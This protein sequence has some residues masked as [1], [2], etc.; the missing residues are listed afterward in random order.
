MCSNIIAKFVSG[1]RIELENLYE[2]WKIYEL[3]SKT[4]ENVLVG[5]I[6]A[7]FYHTTLKKKFN[8]QNK[9]P[10]L[11]G[12]KKRLSPVYPASCHC[13]GGQIRTRLKIGQHNTQ[14]DGPSP[15]LVIPND[16]CPGSLVLHTNDALS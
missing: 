11:I 3:L 12:N 7:S 10:R 13:E 9:S 4:S 16:L 6:R 5:S 8:G 14:V 15:F 2:N 1:R